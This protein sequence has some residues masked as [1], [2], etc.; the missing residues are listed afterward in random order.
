[1]K[2]SIAVRNSIT[3]ETRKKLSEAHKGK[4]INEETRK[5]MSKSNSGVNNGFYGKKHSLESRQKI[6]ANNIHAK[7]TVWINNGK[8][9]KRAKKEDL[10]SYLEKGFVLGRI[11][12][13]NKF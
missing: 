4:I 9:N 1:M 12:P 7:N 10:Q 11:T 6:S 5:K 8:I 3:E 2:I 13:Q